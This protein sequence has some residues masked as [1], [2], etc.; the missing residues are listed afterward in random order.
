M[1]DEPRRLYGD[2]LGTE[3]YDHHSPYSAAGGPGDGDVAFYGRL[4]AEQGGPILD[5]GCGT[6][7]VAVALAEEGFE[8]VGVD[9]SKPMLRQAED[10]RS[11]LPSEVAARLTFRQGDMTRSEGRRGGEGRR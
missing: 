6:G 5:V 10:R 1:R 11:E 8:V 2:S 4:A 3:I 7:R 9:L